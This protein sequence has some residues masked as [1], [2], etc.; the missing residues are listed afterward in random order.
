MAL[1]EELDDKLVQVA[2]AAADV[3]LSAQTVLGFQEGMEDD[4]FF[5]SEKAKISHLT[6][7]VDA[8]YIFRQDL[9]AL[10][11]SLPTDSIRIG[12]YLFE[13]VPHVQEINEAVRIGYAT[14]D[15]FGPF[16]GRYYKYGFVSLEHSSVPDPANNVVLAV[17]MPADYLV[18]LQELRR[19]AI[20]GSILAAMVA[21]LIAWIL[22]T[23]VTGPLNRLGRVALRIQRG[24]MDEPVREERG[25]ELGRL[26]RAMSG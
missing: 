5:L 23:T 17:R 3:G 20:M 4:Q 7:F 19:S 8:A 26:S 11:T 2:G 22:A 12:E 24:R 13:L 14:S 16:D 15:L 21:A 25:G 10:V 1:E 18:P 9:R 6:R